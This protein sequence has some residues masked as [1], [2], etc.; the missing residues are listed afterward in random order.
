MY[1]LTA[2]RCL[3][4]SFLSAGKTRPRISDTT[5]PQSSSKRYPLPPSG[6]PAPP[7]EKDAFLKAILDRVLIHPKHV[8]IRLRVAALIHQLRGATSPIYNSDR[9]AN[10]HLHT[11]AS[12]DCPFRHVPQGCAVKLIVG[13]TQITPE[14]SR[15]AILKAIA[16][17]RLWY[18]QLVDG[19]APSV[20]QLAIMHD[21]SPRYINKI[22][23]LASLSPQ[24][25]E[26]ILTKPES[27]PL[28]L[29]DLINNV[30]IYWKQQTD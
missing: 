5:S 18:E 21:V 28:S 9:N 26:K 19:T 25:V 20:S 11:I 3:R 10:A 2:S 12:I 17:S 13:N 24:S 1:G 29:D 16:R 14:A 8:E 4:A 22:F 23:R 27:L 7:L 30:P 6:H 15:L